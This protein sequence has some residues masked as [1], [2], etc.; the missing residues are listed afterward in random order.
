MEA[1]LSAVQKRLLL[2]LLT[3]VVVAVLA[4]PQPDNGRFTAALDEMVSFHT[5]FVR[6]DAERTLRI[7]AEA[8]SQLSFAD[9]QAVEGA[10]HG[11]KLKLAGSLKPL[12][13][14]TGVRL[15]TLAELHIHAQPGATMSVGTPSA[16][17]LGSALAWRLARTQ[18]N[19]PFTVVDIQLVNAAL[20]EADVALEQQ[21]GQLRQA[22][23]S[24][25]AALDDATRKVAV[26]E[27]R[28]EKRAKRRSRSLEKMQ[29]ALGAARTLLDEK[30]TLH[31]QAQQAYESAAQRA[32]LG[33]APARGALV[34]G[35]QSASSGARAEPDSRAEPHASTLALAQV[36]VE[37][38]GQ[39]STLNIPVRLTRVA[40]PV[41]PLPGA[42][43]LA[44]R[45]AGLWDE[46][47]DMNPEAAAGTIRGH[48]NWHF[49][50][51]QLLGLKLSGSKLLQL[52][53]CI[54]PLLLGLLLL[55]MRSAET[56]YSPFTTR[57]PD[58]LPRVG[59]KSRSLEFV[60]IVLLPLV[61][62]ASAAA[63]L[64]LI[65]QPPVL[66]A[67]TAVACLPLGSLVFAKL[68]EL[69][70]QT[71]SIVRSHSGFP[72]PAE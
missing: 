11:P 71:V 6:S 58:S 56:S 29:V 24:A 43:F 64:L 13:P 66:P 17:E 46:V 5:G 67:L 44:I 34:P 39:R 38:A 23:L 52:M 59:F 37:L 32:E 20:G 18:K 57:V 40:V 15:G 61:A 65:D 8:H 62:I 14:L 36:T 42:Q 47:K 45:A 1:R 50:H 31:A 30:S 19:G 51:V 4:R 49:N 35:A 70:E 69:R 9:M 60:A 28:V 25:R 41:A 54:L 22:S 55:R 48:F 16:E 63:S 68:S 21:V 12:R 53:P 33:A 26:A 2:L 3:S 10:R 72:P 27:R 7:Q